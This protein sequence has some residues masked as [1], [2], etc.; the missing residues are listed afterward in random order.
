MWR[1]SSLCPVCTVQCLLVMYG[2]FIP[3]RTRCARGSGV[4]VRTS[5]KRE[6]RKLSCL[7]GS[8]VGRQL[9]ICYLD[10]LLDWLRECCAAEKLAHSSTGD[11]SIEERERERER[12][13]D[14]I[15]RVWQRMTDWMN[16]WMNE[17]MNE[18]MDGR[19]DGPTDGKPCTYGKP[20]G[21]ERLTRMQFSR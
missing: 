21:V 2:I 9:M 18:W 8:G 11:R 15:G 17:W 5:K 3:F 4:Y 1:A 10:C 12:E 16:G 6:G 20:I 13:R 14:F 7:V 19:T